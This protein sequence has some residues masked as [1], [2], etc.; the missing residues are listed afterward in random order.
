MR[1]LIVYQTSDGQQFEHREDADRH[2]D[3]R[4]GELVTK[5]AHEL[6]Q[7][8][9]YSRMALFID[10]NLDRFVALKALKDDMQLED[11]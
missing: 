9:K 11:E 6:V 5:L 8:D 10:E 1:S 3:R 7:I 2:A 4:Y